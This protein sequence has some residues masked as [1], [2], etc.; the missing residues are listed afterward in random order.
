MGT[1]NLRTY[2]D[3]KA[4][5]SA[6]LLL[7]TILTIELNGNEKLLIQAGL[8]LLFRN[9]MWMITNSNG[10]TAYIFTIHSLEARKFL[11][12]IPVGLARYRSPK[13]K[14]FNT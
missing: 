2:L 4:S 9:L 7:T 10:A 8:N 13:K 5:S 6:N 12:F 11:L 14:F 3:L 1:W